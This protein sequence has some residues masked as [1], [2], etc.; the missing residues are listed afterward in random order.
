MKK[1]KLVISLLVLL[2][3]FQ[4]IGCVSGAPST[5]DASN[6]TTNVIST[7]TKNETE[8]SKTEREI[9]TFAEMAQL[10]SS[11]ENTISNDSVKN[12][13]QANAYNVLPEMLEY[14]VKDYKMQI[15]DNIF[16]VD[17]AMTLSEVVEMLESSSATY[18]YEYNPN[19]IASS[20]RYW[21]TVKKNGIDYFDA[22]F[23][24]SEESNLLADAELR[25]ILPI[26][27]IEN[28]YYPTGFRADG[29]GILYGDA[30]SEFEERFGFENLANNDA[31]HD[32]FGEFFKTTFWRGSHALIQADIDCEHNIGEYL[33]FVF[34]KNTGECINTLYYDSSFGY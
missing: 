14:T 19:A 6:D 26:N 31:W 2:S 3:I 20:V 32:G 16:T 28:T 25:F 27:C 13:K 8:V 7:E 18:E 12:E 17:K 9:A 15:D 33:M 4:I 24:R 22:F 10:D 29:N 23:T 5:N 11:Q 21:L 30:I 1:N 34:D